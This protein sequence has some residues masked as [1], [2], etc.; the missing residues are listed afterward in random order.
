MHK[1]SHI[2]SFISFLHA[3][4]PHECNMCVTIP[5]GS[6]PYTHPRPM[7]ER[8]VNVACARGENDP[9]PVHAT[10]MAPGLCLHTDSQ[11]LCE[12]RMSADPGLGVRLFSHGAHAC[13]A[14]VK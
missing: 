7:S 10:R 12:S 4:P 2:V 1:R 5:H 13:D 8:Y 3:Y 9:R 6:G 11:R 14:Y